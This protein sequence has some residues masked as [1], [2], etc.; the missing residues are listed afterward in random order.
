MCFILRFESTLIHKY[1]YPS[2]FVVAVECSSNDTHIT[3]QRTI[4]I[5][6]PVTE[7][8]VMG[9]YAG[10]LF[11]HVTNCKALYGEAIH[12]QIEAKAGM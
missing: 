2:S 9:C 4:S 3:A 12:I 11:F 1:T 8:S 10:V 6:E 7:L 5:L